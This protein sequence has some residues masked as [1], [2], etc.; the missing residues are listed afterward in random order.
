MVRVNILG[1]L[2]FWFDLENAPDVL[3]FEPIA[4]RLQKKSHVV[5]TTCRN[6]SDLPKL[7]EIYDTSTSIIGWHG[8]KNR[9][10]KYAVGLIRSLL[11]AR[12][13][14]RKKI[15]FAVGFGSRPLALTCG[16]MGIPNASVIDYEHVSISA[17]GR[18]CN[19][20]F[21]PE[22]IHPQ[23]FIDRGVSKEKIIQ[24]SGLKE[25]VYT[26][27]YIPNYKLFNNLGLDENKIIVTI[28]PPSTSAHY[29]DYLSE[30]ICWNIFHRICNDP[31][32]E[33]IY[34]RRNNDKTFDEALQYDNV[35]QMES[36]VKGLDLISISDVVISGGGT[37]SREAA[38]LGIPSYS[39]FTGKQGA[40]D[41]RLSLEGRLTLIR[42][43]EDVD[44]IFFKKHKKM[45]ANQ[46]KNTS[47]LD[48]FANEFIRLAGLYHKDSLK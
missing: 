3:F 40:V 48:F 35:K 28:R 31:F 38:A 13:A 19:Y 37:M 47:V 11:L 16:L 27:S 14:M 7:A 20:F 2:T 29:H 39:I 9:I 21:I 15:D 12:W 22:D 34:V 6:Y 26:N 36:P 41:K 43:P 23:Y 45:L 1:S 33:I 5:Y 10:M 25:D 30:D 8:G 32:I 44:K 42:K 18:F 17:I 4:K 24:F 46:A